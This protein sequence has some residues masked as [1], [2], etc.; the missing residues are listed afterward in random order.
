MK[1]NPALE[2]L[3]GLNLYEIPSK[4]W[5]LSQSEYDP[6]EGTISD[7]YVS[8]MCTLLHNR[9]IANVERENGKTIVLIELNYLLDDEIY[10]MICT[11]KR[12]LEDFVSYTVEQSKHDYEKDLSFSEFQICFSGQ[13]IDCKFIRDEEHEMDRLIFSFPFYNNDYYS[14]LEEPAPDDFVPQLTLEN[15]FGIDL[16]KAVDNAWGQP[17]YH[18]G[19]RLYQKADYSDPLGYF[20]SCNAIVYPGVGTTLYFLKLKDLTTFIH[21]ELCIPELFSMIERDL[22]FK[23]NYSTEDGKKKYLNQIISDGHY[24]PLQLEACGITFGYS[25]DPEQKGCTLVVVLKTCKDR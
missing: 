16:T 10:D 24:N 18:E 13:G 12:G 22:V 3:F 8:N 23:G 14:Q 6:D 9:C 2:N 25:R 19:S 11:L 21:T 17:M 5:T 20:E 1:K 15:F 7:V 4:M